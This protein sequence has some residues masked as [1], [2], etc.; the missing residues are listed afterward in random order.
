[1]LH[2][3]PL[4]ASSAVCCAI[5][6]AGAL[7]VIHAP[8]N[9]GATWTQCVAPQQSIP[10]FLMIFRLLWPRGLPCANLT[11]ASTVQP[12]SASATGRDD[13]CNLLHTRRL[14]ASSGVQ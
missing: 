4:S 11:Q 10:S 5:T 2:V 3:T 7:V 1:M 12:H 6:E 14:L 8:R 9:Q 13:G